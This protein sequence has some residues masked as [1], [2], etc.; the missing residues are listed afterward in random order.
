MPIV[1]TRDEKHRRLHAV[2]SGVITAD[3]VWR[4]IEA[5]HASGAWTYGTL[6]DARE[7]RSDLSAQETQAIVA[8]IAAL[9]VPEPRGPVAVVGRDPVVF[10]MARM[11]SILAENH[12][13][14]IA[15]FMDIAE[16]EAWLAEQ[17]RRR[18]AA[19]TNPAQR[20]PTVSV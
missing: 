10:G 14:E 7:S 15:A 18:A 1:Y 6:V 11:H 8:R 20:V 9:S 12:G 17:S 16:A 3:D 19:E 2:G 13:L 5:Q 4:F